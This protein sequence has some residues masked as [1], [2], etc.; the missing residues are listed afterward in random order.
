MEVGPLN[1]MGLPVKG[2]TEGQP[3][4][5]SEKTTHGNRLVGEETKPVER[6]ADKADIASRGVSLD[7]L[8]GKI[9]LASSA[10][11]AVLRLIE[12]INDFGQGMKDVRD[13]SQ[14]IEKIVSRSS[15]GNRYLTARS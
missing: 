9:V 11:K 5:A 14:G 4:R 13:A 10:Q 7:E 12:T 8:Q 1:N 3:G 2:P 6:G 15:M